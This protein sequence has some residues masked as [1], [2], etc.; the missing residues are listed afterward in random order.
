[1]VVPGRYMLEKFG[2]LIVLRQKIQDFSY[3]NRSHFKSL[4]CVAVVVA[5]Q[6]KL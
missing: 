5:V 4:K 1:M 6:G 3:K 2:I